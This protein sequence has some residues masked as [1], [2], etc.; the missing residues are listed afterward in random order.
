MCI[1]DVIKL[2][3]FLLGCLREIKV[4]YGICLNQAMKTI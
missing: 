2:E 4:S 1:M 3:I